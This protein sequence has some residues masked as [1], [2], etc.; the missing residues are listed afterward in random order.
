VVCGGVVAVYVPLG[1]AASEA[2]AEM[3]AVG[4]VD[5]SSIARVGPSSVC[6][7]KSSPPVNPIMNTTVRMAAAHKWSR[8]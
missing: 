2:G 5:Q 6:W 7:R 1:T 3:A 4:S 8:P